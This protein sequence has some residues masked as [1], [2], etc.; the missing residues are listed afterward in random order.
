[1]SFLGFFQ[2]RPDEL[3]V[4]SGPLGAAAQL[5]A[6]NDVAIENKL[7]RARVLQ[8]MKDLPN[9]A[10]R[11]PEV[12]IRKDDGT[13]SKYCFFHAAEGGVG[14]NRPVWQLSS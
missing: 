13:E 9:L 8:K 4:L 7:L 5:P 11:G 6:V 1:L 10:I 14:D 2:D 3:G 12:N